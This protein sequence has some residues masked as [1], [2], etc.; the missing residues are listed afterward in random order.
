[1][2]RCIHLDGE[3]R[4]RA[5]LS[6][7]TARVLAGLL[8]TAAALCVMAVSSGAQIVDQVVVYSYVPGQGG[9]VHRFDRRLELLGMTPTAAG[10]G[11]SHERGIAVDVQGRLLIPLDALNLKTLVRLTGDGKLLPTTALGHN[12][13]T[14]VALKNGDVF[15]LTRIPLLAPGPLYKVDSSGAVVWSSWAPTAS[16]FDEYAHARTVTTTG[17]LWIGGSQHI[18]CPTCAYQP[19]LT[20]VDPATGAVIRK[21]VLPATAS[22]FNTKLFFLAAAPDGTMWSLQSDNVLVHTDGLSTFEAFPIDAGFNGFISQIRVDAAGDIWASSTNT[23]SGAHSTLLRKYSSTDGSL[24]AEHDVGGKIAGFALGAA[25]QDIC[26]AANSTSVIGLR[27]LV[28]LNLVTGIRSSVPLDPPNDDSVIPNGDPTGFIY[29][30]VIDQQGDNDGDG[31]TNR[32]ET[33]AGSSP[34]DPLSRP[35][36]PK[37]YIDFTAN[38]AIILIFKDPDGL[39][40]PAGGLDIGSISLKTGRY[41]EIFPIVLSFLSFVQVSPDGTEAAAVFG[42]LPLAAGLKLPLDARVT[43]KTG[44]VGWDWQVTPPGEL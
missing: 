22:G 34:Y 37:V 3:G 21:L 35:E 8:L 9:V 19:V 5:A 26:V 39:L 43:D 38:N 41:G 16:Y 36:G 20:R 18:G 1:M 24:L 40:D 28:R 44:A 23:P 15:V 7:S 4:Q 42:A 10:G 33:L 17:A 29:A 11:I 32:A 2:T 27:R 6:G 25:G 30:N 31:A 14:C 12:P 13:L